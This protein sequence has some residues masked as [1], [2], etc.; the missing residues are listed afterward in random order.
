[1]NALQ[2]KEALGSRR[3]PAPLELRKKF[4]VELERFGPRQAQQRL[5]PAEAA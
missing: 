3:T 2:L 4:P 1:V 5:F